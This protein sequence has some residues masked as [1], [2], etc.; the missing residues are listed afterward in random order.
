MAALFEQRPLKAVQRRAR[1]PRLAL[2]CA[3]AVL[4]ALGLASLIRAPVRAAAPTQV[5]VHARDAVVE[6]LAERF[7]RVYLTLDPA[8]LAERGRALSEFGLP[9]DGLAADQAGPHTRR[10]LWTAIA[11]ASRVGDGRTVVTVEADDGRATTYLAV[12]VARAADGRV[13]VA[14]PPAIVGP[15]SVAH[16]RGSVAELEVADPSLRAVIS[17]AVRHYLAG[18]RTD[19]SA[20]LAPR[21]RVSLPPTPV[22]V[23]AIDAVTWLAPKHRVAIDLVGRMPDGTELT[24][25][26]ELEVVRAAGRW[27]V[28]S[29]EVNP[30][31]T[32]VSP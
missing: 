15:P 1:L 3:S 20:D 6:G 18:S 23:G 27:L 16:D 14:S 17:R 9:D 5:R 29:I 4:S 30:S 11:A 19:L 31:D 28:R 32:E 7:A 26:Y 8:H 24:L 10:V 21:A 12:P 13:F 22:R 25:R 2:I